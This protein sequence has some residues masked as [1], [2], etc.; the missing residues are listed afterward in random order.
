M[1]YKT[2]RFR[3]CPSKKMIAIFEQTLTLCCELYNA[4]LQERRDAWEIERKQLYYVH[5]SAQLP[6]IKTDRPEFQLIYAQVLQSTLRRIDRT[7]VDFFRRVK[8]GGVKPGYP[9]FRS[10]SRY[11]S[12][13]Y[14]QHGFWF[15]GN[16]LTLSKIGTCRVR[17]SRPIDGRIKTLTV[18]REVDGWYIYLSVEIDR[19]KYIPKT[20]QAIGV[21][22]GIESFATL[23]TGDQIKVPA[24]FRQAERG[25]KTAQRRVSRRKYRGSNRKKA[26][27]LLAKQ[28]LKVRR[29]KVDL[30]H[31][32][33]LE[34]IHRFD[35]FI[36][37]DLH[38]AGMVRNHHLAKVISEA[39]WNTFLDIHIG[40]AE[41]AGRVVRLVR[42][43][44]TSQDCS[45]CGSRV[46]KTLSER[47]HRC[48]ECGLVL[49]R[50]HNAA[51]NILAR[52]E[53]LARVA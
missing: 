53:P 39:A 48:I 2:Y 8:R 12:F 43:A 16:K 44:F 33:S 14:P 41:N 52:A 21:D 10:R 25:V 46:R 35:T 4:A 51:I 47:E 30:F 42:A 13:T 6:A 26:I 32:L 49:H 36:F 9:R 38:I 11:G 27:R 5:Q 3:L 34:L 37:E 15:K 40:K 22:M 45:S 28:H 23:S 7:F 50:D 17:L 19:C 29:Q 18:K 1:D 31:K 20:G 24:F